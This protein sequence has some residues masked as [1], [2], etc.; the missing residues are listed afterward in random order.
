MKKSQYLSFLLPLIFIF[1]C[2]PPPTTQQPHEY[3]GEVEQLPISDKSFQVTTFNIRWYGQGGNSKPSHE[4]RN[5][6][7]SAFLSHYIQN[8]DIL[9]FQEIVD[10]NQFQNQV[11]AGQMNCLNY[12]SNL[13][14]HQFIIIC[15]RPGLYFAP[16]N[17]DRDYIIEEV[18]TSFALRPAIHTVITDG[19]KVLSHLIGLHLKAGASLENISTRRR[20]MQALINY[21]LTKQQNLPT[22]VAGDLNSINNSTIEIQAY[23]DMFALSGLSLKAIPFFGFTYNNGRYQGKLDHILVNHHLKLTNG[24]FIGGPCNM[25]SEGS[26]Y[27]NLQFYNRNISDHCPL[28]VE[29]SYQPNIINNSDQ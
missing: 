1:G 7:L 4:H 28:S 8:H 3:H 14:G 17:K 19:Q 26:G 2:T 22:I 21:L 15:I 11:I 24:P 6:W 18:A 25:E 9:I 12:N 29:L 13:S 5:P 23:D 16:F 10:P 20:Q 27:S